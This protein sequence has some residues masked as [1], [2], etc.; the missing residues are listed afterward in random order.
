MTITRVS[1]QALGELLGGII[2]CSFGHA[3]WGL[4]NHGEAI[5]E[6]SHLPYV[7]FLQVFMMV[8]ISSLSLCQRESGPLKH[9]FVW[10]VVFSISDVS[11]RSNVTRPR[12]E[13][14]L[15]FKRY[16]EMSWKCV[17]FLGVPPSC[18]GFFGPFPQLPPI[19]HVM[20]S[21]VLGC[22]CNLWNRY[23]LFYIC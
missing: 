9:V 1:P 8:F 6:S 22:Y 7:L 4:N 16:F 15:Q 19:L 2:G 12:E 11:A 21:C 18:L 14:R 23:S 3:A 20:K 13:H 17:E 5:N 10:K